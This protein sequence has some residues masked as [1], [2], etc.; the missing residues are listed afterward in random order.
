MLWKGFTLVKSVW[1]SRGF[2]YLNVQNFLEIWEIFCNYF[3]EY[4]M[5]SFGLQIFAF[6]NDHD[7]QAGSFDGVI[8]FVHL[9]FISLEL[10]D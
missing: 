4:I 6:Y 1:C 2:L 7:A 8:E 9:P 10:F 5:Y 3:I